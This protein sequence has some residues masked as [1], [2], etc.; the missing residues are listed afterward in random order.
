MGGPCPNAPLFGVDK[1]EDVI[2]FIDQ[3]ITCVMPENDSNLLELVN[4]QTRRHSHTCRKNLKRI[5]D[6]TILSHL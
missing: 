1:D 5:V 3:I 4:R 6:L 2:A